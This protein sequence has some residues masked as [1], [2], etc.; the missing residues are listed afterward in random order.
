VTYSSR[1]VDKRETFAYKASVARHF[2][3]FTVGALGERVTKAGV[4]T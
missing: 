4:I 3:E 2:N 1:A